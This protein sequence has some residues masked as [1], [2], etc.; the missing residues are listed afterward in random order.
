MV[1]NPLLDP[2]IPKNIKKAIEKI[3]PSPP[4]GPVY[5]PPPTPPPKAPSV[6]K[7]APTP[8]PKPVPIV[9]PDT[10]SGS[11]GIPAPPGATKIIGGKVKVILPKTSP[12]VVDPFYATSMGEKLVRETVTWEYIEPSITPQ[13]T[14][15]LSH[16]AAKYTSGY[17]EG[18]PVHLKKKYET[19]YETAIITGKTAPMKEFW[20]S[21][22]ERMR[23]EEQL[24]FA[25]LFMG[26]K[27]PVKKKKDEPDIWGKIGSYIFMP[28]GERIEYTLAS[29]RE[30]RFSKGLEPIKGASIFESPGMIRVREQSEQTY[31]NL[32]KKGDW[33]GIGG[34]V[35]TSPL[36]IA[37]VS[38]A[39]GAGMGAL[40]VTTWGSKGVQIGLLEK[41]IGAAPAWTYKYTITVTRAGAI[42]ASVGGYF[43]YE[44]VKG[45]VKAAK[46]DRLSEYLGVAAVMMPFVVLPYKYGTRTGM[47]YVQRKAAMAKVTDPPGRVQQQALYD[48]MRINRRLGEPRYDVSPYDITQVQKMTPLKATEF[49]K[50]MRSV[51]AK[52]IHKTAIGGSTAMEIQMQ[53][54]TFRAGGYPKRLIDIAARRQ[55]V[56]LKSGLQAGGIKPIKIGGVPGDIDILL[57]GIFAKEKSPSVSMLQRLGIHVHKSPVRSYR[58]YGETLYQSVKGKIISD[59]RIVDVKTMSI[60]EQFLRTSTNILPS[61]QKIT[62]YRAY[63]DL[64]TWFD[65]GEILSF[66]KGGTKLRVAMD[67]FLYPEKYPVPKVTLGERII[68][69]MGGAVQPT[70]IETIGGYVEPVYPSYVYPQVSTPY[71][72][73]GGYAAKP[74]AVGKILI[75]YV[76][77]VEIDYKKIIPVKETPVFYPKVDY[78]ME[79]KPSVIQAGA[80]PK[81]PYRKKLPDYIPPYLAPSVYVSSYIPDYIPP[82]PPPY[83]PD[84]IPSDYASYVPDYV[85]L[86]PSLPPSPKKGKKDDISKRA[87]LVTGQGFAPFVKDR[88]YVKGKKT[89]SE[90]YIRMGETPLSEK[91]AYRFGGYL[92]DESVARSFKV[93]PVGGKIQP[94]GLPIPS[95]RLLSGKFYKKDNRMIEKTD[96]AIDSPGELEGITAKGILASMERTSKKARKVIRQPKIRKARQV[97]VKTEHVKPIKKSIDVLDEM[98]KSF[99]RMNRNMLKGRM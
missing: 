61:E 89:Y 34:R 10:P 26:Y 50:Y 92:T 13:M 23:S 16:Q 86:P 35:I 8:T 46:E 54:G 21:Y 79:K 38:Y 81:D 49:T 63:K 14:Y 24:I 18:I 78:S 76:S 2:F 87:Y 33:L 95:W 97:R 3:A 52:Y 39:A 40:K 70:Y 64:P 75:D 98:N 90:R 96:Y 71:L 84:Y 66:Q 15:I 29:L 83:V 73:A 6:P 41:E 56:A 17:E 59:K 27:E 48:A 82:V 91:D 58:G 44:M 74:Y 32:W 99:E 69:R 1:Y 51:R 31:L 55:Q 11:M 36:P 28:F 5:V 22:F 85:L 60:R 45:G 68:G 43:G 37:G 94:L 20:K 72:L 42:E 93:K 9:I 19:I 65:T 77:T 30:K 47:G 67:K 4:L 12:S 57:R 25:K 80:Y 62:G 53:K 88:V 7:L